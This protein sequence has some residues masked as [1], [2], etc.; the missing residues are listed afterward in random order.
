[1]RRAAAA[2]GPR[3]TAPIDGSWYDAEYFETGIKSNW[4]DGYTWP[5]FQ[6]LFRDAAAYLIAMFPEAQSFLDAGCAKGFLVRSLRDAGKDAKGFDASPWAISHALE[7]ARPFLR[8]AG[9]DEY[10][11]D[12]Q[13]DVLLCFDLFA[14]LTEDQVRSFLLRA[15]G[16]VRLALVAVIATYERPGE[17]PPGDRDPSH[18]TRQTRPWWDERIRE[19]GWRQDRLHRNLERLCRQHELPRRMGWSVYVYS[20]E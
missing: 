14:H 2:A 7:E 11:F 16:Q 6:K 19:A 4:A 9:V 5:L 20:P 1:M 8:L 3:L 10:T 15:R 13:V 12:E 18:I 17:E